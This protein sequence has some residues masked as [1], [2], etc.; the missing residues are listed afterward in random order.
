MAEVTFNFWYR[1][2][3]ALYKTEDE[4]KAAL[5]RPYFESLL[6]ALCVHCRLETD[7]VS[8]EIIMIN[9][10]TNNKWIYRNPKWLMRMFFGQLWKRSGSFVHV[11]SDTSGLVWPSASLGPWKLKNHPH[12]RPHP[13]PPRSS[14]PLLPC[15]MPYRL[16]NDLRKIRSTEQS[17]KDC[18][19]YCVSIINLSKENTFCRF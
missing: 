19:E 17:T 13:T 9:S 14:P 7:A 3:E 4:A 18:K 2:S 6:E 12:P 1:L 8:T 16:T 10:T 11:W 5:F 15:I